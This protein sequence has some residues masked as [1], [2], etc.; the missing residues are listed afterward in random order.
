MGF[1]GKFMVVLHSA[2]AIAVLTWAAGVYTQRI[3]WNTPPAKEGKEAVPGLYER[4]KAAAAQ[5]STV[6]DKAYYRWSGNLNQVVVLEAE[7]YPRRNFYQGQL[8]LVQS[9]SLVRGGMAAPPPPVQDLVPAPNGFLDI[10]NPTGRKA[11]E[12]RPMVPADSIVGYETKMV[13]LVQDIKA[14][15]DRNAQA[16]VDRE[17]LNREIVGVTQPTV[18][19]GLRTLLLE[20]KTIYDKAHNEDM[21]V[22][23]FV[24]NRE[25]EF[26]L[27]R[28]R[29]DAMNG[30]IDELVKFY[31]EFPNERPAGVNP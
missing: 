20:Q 21:Y 7:R 3:H 8:E 29:R 1:I 31:K 24:T 13:K 22:V 26:G 18:I 11:F 23:N 15:Q 25:A 5:F 19:K 12:V 27:L 14:S 10:R 16:I 9:G 28:K 30:R 6:V 4:Q 17:K 2:L